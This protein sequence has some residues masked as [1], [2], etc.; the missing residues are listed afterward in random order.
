ML[1]VVGTKS[2]HKNFFKKWGEGNYCMNKQPYIC[3]DIQ[4]NWDQYVKELYVLLHPLYYYP[5]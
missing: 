4:R 3:T 2:E 5:Q 1:A